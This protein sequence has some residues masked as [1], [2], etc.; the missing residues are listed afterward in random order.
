MSDGRY[1]DMPFVPSRRTISMRVRAGPPEM[2]AEATWFA[3]IV[4]SSS[5]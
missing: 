2:R 5:L 1:D 3:S 4:R